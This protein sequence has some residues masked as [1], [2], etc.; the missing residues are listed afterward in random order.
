MDCWG[1]SSKFSMMGLAWSHWAA[2]ICILSQAIFNSNCKVQAHSDKVSTW[3]VH[4]QQS[5][6]IAIYMPCVNMSYIGPRVLSLGN[7]FHIGVLTFD[8]SG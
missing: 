3:Y 1:I 5:F 8:C 2:T 4:T 6:N 7:G